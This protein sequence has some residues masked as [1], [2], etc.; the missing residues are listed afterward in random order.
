[1]SIS[2]AF[3]ALSSSAVVITLIF[4]FLQIRQTNK[5]QQALLQQGRSTRLSE[6]IGLRTQP[7]LGEAWMRSLR[8]D[9]TLD[10]PQ[11]GVV[12]AWF[13][14]AFINFEDSFLQ[15]KAGLFPPGSWLSDVAVM[16]TFLGLPVARVAWI[17]NRSTMG[18]EFVAYVDGLIRDIKPQK[19]FEMRNFWNAAMAAELAKAE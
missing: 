1:M 13:T 16:K 10:E 15:H 19:P 9:M 6:L 4:L 7:F 14:A 3:S 8:N 5:N 17:T 12:F 11:I 18:E 2:E